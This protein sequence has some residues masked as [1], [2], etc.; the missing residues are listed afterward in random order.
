LLGI[1]VG[2]CGWA[3][4]ILVD[5]NFI[6]VAFVFIWTAPF[7]VMFVLTMCAKIATKIRPDRGVV[8]ARIL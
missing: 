3:D 4:V 7:C 5:R 8:P 2:A 1:Y 6:W